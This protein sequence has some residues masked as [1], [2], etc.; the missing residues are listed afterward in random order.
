MVVGLKVPVPVGSSTT[1][2]VTTLAKP[3][4]KL[5]V[6]TMRSGLPW[7]TVGAPPMESKVK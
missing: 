4:L 6:V 3:F 7:T 5:Q 1:V 2:G